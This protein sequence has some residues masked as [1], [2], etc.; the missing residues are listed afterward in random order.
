MSIYQYQYLNNHAYIIDEDYSRITGACTLGYNSAE[1]KRLRAI[2]D[3]KFDATET[4]INNI[5]Q[6]CYHQKIPSASPPKFLQNRRKSLGGKLD[7]SE[8]CEDLK[9]IYHFLNEP[10]MQAHLH[11]DFRKY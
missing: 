2:Q 9:G 3:K 7:D 11:V 4:V 8:T 6:P 1:C 10:T 5:Y